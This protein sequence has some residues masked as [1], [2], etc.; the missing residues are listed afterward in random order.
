MK[1]KYPHVKGMKNTASATLKYVSPSY[2]HSKLL[3]YI[4]ILVLFI[5]HH[6]WTYYYTVFD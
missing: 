2:A 4:A 1:R 5:G 6:I 3:C